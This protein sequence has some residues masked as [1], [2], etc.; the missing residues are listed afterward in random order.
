MKG[1]NEIKDSTLNP[2]TREKT[3][4]KSQTSLPHGLEEE[5]DGCTYH[6]VRWKAENWF[7]LT[8]VFSV[9]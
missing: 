7:W 5:K 3:K 6:Y 8:P 9:R 2:W 4:E 1:E